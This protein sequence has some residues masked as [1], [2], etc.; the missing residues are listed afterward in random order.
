MKNSLILSLLLWACCYFVIVAQYSLCYHGKIILY[1]YFTTSLFLFN[2]VCLD[3]TVNY[4]NGSVSR[5]N[6]GTVACG[7][8]CRYTHIE[9]R[10]SLTVYRKCS[11]TSTCLTVESKTVCHYTT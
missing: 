7:H 8:G 4:N 9:H 3:L 6:H 2:G 5:E 11:R 10:D 1:I